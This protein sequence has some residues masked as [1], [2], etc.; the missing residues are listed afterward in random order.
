M[1]MRTFRR[2]AN[3]SG[4]KNTQYDWGTV[5]S[6]ANTET[7]TTV[8]TCLDATITDTK[9]C[10]P[11]SVLSS[12]HLIVDCVETPTTMTLPGARQE[13]LVYIDRGGNTISATPCA[14][15]TNE[16]VPVPE[17]TRDIREATLAYKWFTPVVSMPSSTSTGSPPV[18]KIFDIKFRNGLVMRANDAIRFCIRNTATVGDIRYAYQFVGTTHEG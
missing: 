2:M 13:I 17:D 18:R 7:R 15:F 11:D 10:K 12:F 5:S 1:R 6:A 8:L 3:F 9:Q 16:T 4:P 14:D